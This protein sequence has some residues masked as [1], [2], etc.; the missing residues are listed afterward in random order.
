MTTDQP[1]KQP[2]E[3]VSFDDLQ[4]EVLNVPEREAADAVS[5]SPGILG[6]PIDPSELPKPEGGSLKERIFAQAKKEEAE[7][8]ALQQAKDQASL[9]EA[10]PDQAVAQSEVEPQPGAQPEVQPQTTAAP[11]V[12][13]TAPLPEPPPVPESKPEITGE[14]APETAPVESEGTKPSK[15]QSQ[16]QTTTA[17]AAGA[18][19]QAVVEKT[20]TRKQ[21]ESILQEGLAPMFLHMDPKE[22]QAFTAAANETASKLELLVTQFKASARE[23]LRLIKAWLSKIPKVNKYFLEQASKIKT[24][25]I[26]QVQAQ[27]K[28][29]S[30]LLR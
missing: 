21:I 22:R 6:G 10:D 12:Q 24:D 18:A 29:E 11:E 1:I 5:G 16:T 15:P 14:V 8:A 3:A 30:R 20:E 9:K 19:A 26:L 17:P 25:E 23:V 4:P 13:P 28:K 27:K 7:A 2:Q